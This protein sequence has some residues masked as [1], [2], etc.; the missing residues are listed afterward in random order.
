MTPKF[1]LAQVQP[2]FHKPLTRKTLLQGPLPRSE[3]NHFETSSALN[4]GAAICRM[5]LG[6]L[7]TTVEFT[8]NK[9]SLRHFRSQ[10]RSEAWD[11][12]QGIAKK[13]KNHMFTWFTDSSSLN[14]KRSGNTVLQGETTQQGGTSFTFDLHPLTPVVAVEVSGW[15]TQSEP[16]RLPWNFCY[17]SEAIQKRSKGRTPPESNKG[18]TNVYNKKKR[19]ESIHGLWNVC[20]IFFSYKRKRNVSYIFLWKKLTDPRLQNALQ[21]FSICEVLHAQKTCRKTD[22]KKTKEK[23]G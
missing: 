19:K 3:H 14:R 1:Y 11:E 10:A 9:L 16:W 23:R 2:K 6:Q 15:S 4:R 12:K 13:A 7:Y 17:S 21:A 18:W 22:F 8:K 5:H 20:F